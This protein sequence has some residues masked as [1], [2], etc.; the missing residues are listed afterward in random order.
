[1]LVSLIEHDDV[2]KAK[3]VCLSC[4]YAMLE[5]PSFKDNTSH[6]YIQWNCLFLEHQT[7]NYR[8]YIKIKSR[9]FNP[10]TIQSCKQENKSL[11]CNNHFENVHPII[12]WKFLILQTLGFKILT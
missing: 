4:L 12:N 8:V 3:F 5:L 11:T 9:N 7:Q 2:A 6:V 10:L 1:M